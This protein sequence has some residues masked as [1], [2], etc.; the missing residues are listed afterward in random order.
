MEKFRRSRRLRENYNIR[1][2][3]RE[4]QVNID[5][6]IYPIFIVPGE[7]IKR[8][9][10]HLPGQYHFSI[11][12]LVD[13][14]A[15][16]KALGIKGIILF[17]LPEYKDEIASSAYDMNG[18]I[19]RAIREIR[20]AHDD[21]YIITDVCMCQYS[22]TGHCGIVNLNGIVENDSTLEVLSKIA[23]SHARAGANMIAP[24][25]MMDGRVYKIREVLDN[26][27]FSHIPIMSY[28]AKYASAY[29]GPF[30]SAANSSP[31]FGDRKTYQ[32]DFGN[33]FEALRQVEQ[34]IEEGADMVMVKPALAYLDIIRDVKDAC[35]VPVVAY[36]VSGEYAMIK[37]GA[38][39]GLLNEE[40]T[41]VETLTAIK[42][43]GADVIITYFAKDMA[44][45]IRREIYGLK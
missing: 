23:L 40:E 17:G 26:N 24:S 8:E 18:I 7:N 33:R 28:S 30:R 16:V 44:K 25:D 21:I 22:S 45:Y 3:S 27:N 38:Q 37:I 43:S 35:K 11:D 12:K 2:L 1:A 6:L 4:V 9:I 20:E 10:D 19:Q 13:E 14:V 39:N 41:M 29:Y 15:E 34:D 5:D 42:R 36:N 32:M 31:K